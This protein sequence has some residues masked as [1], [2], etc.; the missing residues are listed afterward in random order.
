MTEAMTRNIPEIHSVEGFDPTAFARKLTNDDGT[1]S[2]Y[3]DVKYRMLWFRLA[4]PSGKIDSEIIHTDD[5]SAVVCCRLYADKADPGDQYIAKSMAQ[6]FLSEEKYGDRFLEI[7]ETAAI[8]RALASAGYGTQFCGNTDLGGNVIADAPMEIPFDVDAEVHSQA[9]QTLPVM[10]QTAFEAQS[11]ASMVT[12]APSS[13]E[14]AKLPASLDE[15]IEALSVEDAKQVT[16]DVG[17]YS[18]TRLGDIAIQNPADLEWYVRKYAGR[19]LKMKAA[20]TV[21]MRAAL[22]RAS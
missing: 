5:K 13:P 7:A 6:R 17:H 10:Q 8:G 15:W 16:V 2:M 1:Q 3:L 22:E 14:P 20:A 4:N 21:L 11:T 9:V 18:G 12:P 19:N